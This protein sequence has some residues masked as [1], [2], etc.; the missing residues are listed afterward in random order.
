VKAFFSSALPKNCWQPTASGANRPFM[1]RLQPRSL[2]P[3]ARLNMARV[4]SAAFDLQLRPDRPD[5]GDGFARPARFR[6]RTPFMRFQD[7]TH[8]IRY[9][10]TPG[11]QRREHVPL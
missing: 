3:A 1:R 2:M 4:A 6:S 10:H 9:G 8:Q 7:N 5:I 11:L